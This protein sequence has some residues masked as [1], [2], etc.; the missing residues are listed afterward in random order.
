[1]CVWFNSSGKGRRFWMRG[2]PRAGSVIAA[3]RSSQEWNAN[4]ASGVSDIPG[5]MS[6][7]HLIKQEIAFPGHLGS[8]TNQRIVSMLMGAQPRPWRGAAWGAAL[9]IV[10][11][12][13]HIQGKSKT[14]SISGFWWTGRKGKIQMLSLPATYRVLMIA[15]VLL[16]SFLFTQPV[17]ECEIWEGFSEQQNKSCP[18][19]PWVLPWKRVPWHCSYW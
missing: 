11:C 8:C 1:M 2:Q 17:Y 19:V 4:S 9:N 18:S 14:D 12:E 3:E 13:K 16:S 7:R 6:L 5:S 10:F 15:L